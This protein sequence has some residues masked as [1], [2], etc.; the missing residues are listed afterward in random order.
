[1]E[2][3]SDHHADQTLG[4]GRGKEFG[5]RRGSA[6]SVEPRPSSWGSPKQ[7]CLL[8][9]FDIGP[10][11]LGCC[12]PITSTLAGSSLGREW[13]HVDTGVDHEGAAVGDRSANCT[14][15]QVLS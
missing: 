12:T 14:S 2:R 7:N 1:M 5:V 10:E 13:P 3:A 15:L 9:E 4:K 8:E 6:C 11:G